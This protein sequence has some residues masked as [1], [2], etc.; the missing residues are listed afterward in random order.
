M[1]AEDT[2]TD[3]SSIPD[4]HLIVAIVL[5]VVLVI[6]DAFVL[7]QGGISVLIGVWIVF[8]SMPVAAFAK[9][10]KGCR[11]RRFTILG[12]YL[13]AVAAVIIGINLL[14]DL[15]YYRGNELA[16]AIASYK[17]HTGHYPQSLQQLVPDYME[18]IKKAKPVLGV[19]EFDYRI[20]EDEPVLMFM[21]L[22]P[23]G[24]AQYNFET[25]QWE[26]FD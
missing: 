19:N 6:L 22:P 11:G 23:F 2:K 13:S 9:R 20:R 25:R 1:T 15:A 12:V 3:S 17:Q 8:V 21:Y 24:T 4:W 18:R 14:N 7:N 5:A 16:T 10:Y 26:L